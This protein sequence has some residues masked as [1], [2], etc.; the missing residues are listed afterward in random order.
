MLAI[1]YEL[2]LQQLMVV[3]TFTDDANGIPMSEDVK[4]D[5][6]QHQL[7][8]NGFGIEGRDARKKVW[9]MSGLT[10]QP[11]VPLYLP[12][13]T[14]REPSNDMRNLL[15]LRDGEVRSVPDV[16]PGW[17]WSET[18]DSFFGSFA[19]WEAQIA[20]RQVPEE[21]MEQNDPAPVEPCHEWLSP[22]DVASPSLSNVDVIISNVDVAPPGDSRLPSVIFDN[23]EEIMDHFKEESGAQKENWRHLEAWRKGHGGDLP[24]NWPGFSGHESDRQLRVNGK[25]TQWSIRPTDLGFVTHQDGK[26][27]PQSDWRA[28]SSLLEKLQDLGVPDFIREQRALDPELAS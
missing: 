3:I 17:G 4:D 8:L 5:I 24:P 9:A 10:E 1:D 22:E 23:R 21:Q 7:S 28:K 18:P 13:L 6:A 11:M 26:P 20:M 27:L 2:R 15:A 16:I 19:S 25:W 14:N 12:Y